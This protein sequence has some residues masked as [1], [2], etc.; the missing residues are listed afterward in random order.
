MKVIVITKGDGP[1]M[2]DVLEMADRIEAE[3]YE[4]ERVDF[5][6]PEARQLTELY[7][8]YSTPALLVVENDGRVVEAWQALLPTESEIKNLLRL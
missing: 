5:D 8:I 2:R 6:D 3:T 4:V 1:E 7:D